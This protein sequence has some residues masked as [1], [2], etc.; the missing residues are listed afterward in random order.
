MG[1]I[2]E[3]NKSRGDLDVRRIAFS[4]SVS[5]TEHDLIEIG[6]LLT[7]TV[8]V[9]KDIRIPANVWVVTANDNSFRPESLGFADLDTCYFTS[10]L[11]A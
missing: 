11:L 4:R 1:I 10:A 5:L 8:H 3:A 7:L 2:R 6:T 9:Q